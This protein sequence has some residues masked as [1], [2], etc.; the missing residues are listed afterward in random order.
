VFKKTLG[1]G[2]IF[3]S[4]S[5]QKADQCVLKNA[6][7]KSDYLESKAKIDDE[8]LFIISMRVNEKKGHS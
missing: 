6:G 1:Y 7:C 2:Q 3:S 4:L 5:A 8:T